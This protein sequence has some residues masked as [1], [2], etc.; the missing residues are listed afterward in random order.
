MNKRKWKSKRKKENGMD[1]INQY[2]NTAFWRS[3]KGYQAYLVNHFS[4]LASGLNNYVLIARDK[5]SGSN[6]SKSKF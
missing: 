4:P 1:T 6:P 3:T 2:F 5:N